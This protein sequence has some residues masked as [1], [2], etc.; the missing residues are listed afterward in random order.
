VFAGLSFILGELL[1]I[2]IAYCTLDT[3]DSGNWRLLIIC[4]AALAIL[5]LIAVFVWGYESP[6]FLLNTGKADKAV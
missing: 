3:L 4:S 1:T 5:P 2:L 6:R